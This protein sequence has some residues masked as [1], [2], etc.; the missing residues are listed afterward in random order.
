M[1]SLSDHTRRDAEHA[2]RSLIR[3]EVMRYVRRMDELAKGHI[4]EAIEQATQEGN[5]IDG[6]D[7]GK[8]AATGAIRAYIGSGE[9][10]PAIEAPSKSS[11]AP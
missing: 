11:D 2:A 4:K 6:T 3:V 5:A 9:P 7:L 8:T 1:P 10:Q